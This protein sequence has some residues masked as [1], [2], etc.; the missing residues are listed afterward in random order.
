MAS[1]FIL[2]KRRNQATSNKKECVCRSL[3]NLFLGIPMNAEKKYNR[4]LLIS[5]LSF[6]LNSRNRG[7]VVFYFIFACK[8]EARIAKRFLNV[9][10]VANASKAK[11]LSFHSY[12]SIR[13]LF[14]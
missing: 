9:M 11:P 1:R 3:E 10:Q 8:A 4:K 7:S 13:H 6:L 14:E 5:S 2:S 12:M